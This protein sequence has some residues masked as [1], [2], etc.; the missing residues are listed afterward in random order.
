MYLYVNSYTHAH[1]WDVLS[2]LVISDR[3]VCSKWK[4]WGKIFIFM[5]KIYN[6][7]KN[8]RHT[9]E[10]I[11]CDMRRWKLLKDANYVFFC[12]AS[13]MLCVMKNDNFVVHNF[14]EIRWWFFSASR[15]LII[16]IFAFYLQLKG[17]RKMFKEFW[18]SCF[19]FTNDERRKIPAVIFV[20]KYELCLL[21][22]IMTE[23]LPAVNTRLK[24]FFERF[25]WCCLRSF[26]SEIKIFKKF[27]KKLQKFITN[28]LRSFT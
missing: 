4:V 14:I 12:W 21:T 5:E 27:S 19:Q 13:L 24:Y 16:R 11:A 20:Q 22:A 25:S 9:L 17:K 26:F 18:D 8:M 15:N 10:C 1:S 7:N 28:V 6:N 23:L 3:Q 2:N